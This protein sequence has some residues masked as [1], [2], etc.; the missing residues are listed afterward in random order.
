[1]EIVIS[2]TLDDIAKEKPCFWYKCLF[3]DGNLEFNTWDEKYV[4]THQVP[5][6][7][8]E[9]C[10]CAPLPFFFSIQGANLGHQ[11]I[12]TYPHLLLGLLKS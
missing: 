10:H 5:Q 8:N 3:Q 2:L 11:A 4:T 9:E 7:K 6:E 1:V 12:Y